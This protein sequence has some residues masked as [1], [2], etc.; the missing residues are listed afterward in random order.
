PR[1]SDCSG[2]PAGL[3]GLGALG[4]SF[5]STLAMNSPAAREP[6]SYHWGSTLWHEIAHAVTLGASAHR[7]P[8]WLT[9]GISVHEERRARPGWGDGFSV[10]FAIAWSSDRLRPPSRL[11]D[12]FVRPR[13]P[14]EVG[15]SYYMA[16]LVVQWIEDTRGL[17]AL[18]AML[19]GYREG[20]TNADV[21]QRTLDMAPEQMDREFDAWLRERY[22]TQLGAVTLEDGRAGGAFLEQLAAGRRALDAG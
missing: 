14:G 1:H 19:A 5:G 6:G 15:L 10:D 7:V 22:A 21:V 8:R 18:R 3:A 4:V 9:E 11:N 13:C 17:P 12:G 20:R 2:R 16:S